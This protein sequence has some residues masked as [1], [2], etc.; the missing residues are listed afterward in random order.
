MVKIPG[1]FDSPADRNFIPG[2]TYVGDS[3][4]I[5][6][7]IFHDQSDY[8]DV[9]LRFDGQKPTFMTFKDFGRIVEYLED[10]STGKAGS[11]M[12]EPNPMKVSAVLLESSRVHLRWNNSSSVLFPLEFFQVLNVL[13]ASKKRLEKMIRRKHE[14]QIALGRG[15]LLQYMRSWG[16]LGIFMFLSILNLAMLVGLALQYKWFWHWLSLTLSM[17]IW[18]IFFT[19]EW[20][21]KIGPMTRE[22]FNEKFFYELTFV[23]F[24]RRAAE[25]FLAV[26][27]CL[28]LYALI[29]SGAAETI[30]DFYRR[31]ARP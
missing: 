28:A 10:F 20:T 19:P 15:S 31:N 30:I 29:G 5:G 11:E 17:S 24:P 9:L 7:G 12:L 3:R 13:I 6:L 27:I 25:I 26:F 18:L 2:A 22:Y 4:L 1:R 23:Q 14:K 16:S 8:S 21:S